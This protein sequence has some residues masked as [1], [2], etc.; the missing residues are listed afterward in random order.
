MRFEDCVVVV[1]GGGRGIG[2]ATAR[3]F[4]AEGA[5]V[6]VTDR[7]GDL[8]EAVAAQISAAG[9]SAESHAV[10]VTDTAAV[11]GL[12]TDVAGR[13]GR[14]DVLV[15]CPARATDA[16]FEEVTG[17]GFDEDMNLT[18]KAPFQT[19][20]AGLPALLRSE[21][22]AVVSIG[23]VNGIEA[24]GNEV[25]AAAKAGL[26]NLTRNLA[27]RYGRLGVRFNLVAPGTV[28]TANW[29]QR[30]A[31]DPAVLDEIAA[32]YPLGRVGTPE[33]IAGAVAFLA[34][35]DASWITGVVLPVDGGITAGH[36]DLITSVFGEDF[37]ATTTD[38]R[39]AR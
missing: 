19:I 6:V 31:A 10:D 25:Y 29:D 5:C 7:E 21:H 28:R 14:V 38:P 16:H 23:S 13:C 33:D 34:S 9:G 15:S 30:L 36:R 35:P 26:A 2:A 11:S 1:T 27:V 8:A 39:R 3:R 20:Q 32:L 24:F 18:L 12:F 37:F 22:P 17:A 4:G